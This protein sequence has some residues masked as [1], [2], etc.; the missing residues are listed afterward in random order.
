MTRLKFKNKIGFGSFVFLLATGLAT[1]ADKGKPPEAKPKTDARVGG[2]QLL[3]GYKHKKLQGIDSIV[4]KIEK[5]GGLSI[6]YEIGVV[7]PPGAPRFGGG[8][9]D[10]PKRTPPK[11]RHWYKEQV[12]NGVPMH[13]AY[14]KNGYLLVSFQQ[15]RK[16]INFTVKVKNSDEMVEALLMIMTYPQK[17]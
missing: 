7:S 4:G 3:S 16:G 9:S 10:R 11:S 2:M 17:K 6:M 14:T 13:L 5:P 12:V 8:F 1:A 15:S